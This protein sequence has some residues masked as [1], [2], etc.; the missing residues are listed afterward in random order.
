MNSNCVWF[1]EPLD[2]ATNAV[3]SQHLSTEDECPEKKCSDGQKRNLWACPD[4][5]FVT[6]LEREIKRLKLRFNIWCRKGNGAIRYWSLPK[7]SSRVAK[8]NDKSVPF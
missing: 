4:H 8:R 1:V 7:K 3:I 5:A 6:R 2:S